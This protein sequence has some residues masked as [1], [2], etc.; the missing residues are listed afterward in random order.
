MSTRFKKVVL[1]T[2]KS[3]KEKKID[4]KLSINKSNNNVNAYIRPITKSTIDNENEISLLSK[5]REENSFAFPTQF[6]VTLEG[7]KNWTKQLIINPTRILFFIESDEKN[8]KIIGHLGFYS[9]DFNEDSCEIDNVIR[10]E[11]NYLKGAMTLAMKT[12][13]GWAIDKLHPKKIYLRVFSDNKKAIKFYKACGFKK[14]L[15]I[16]LEKEERQNYVSWNENKKLAKAEKY[17]LKM[18]YQNIK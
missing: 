13:I 12:M 15:L 7:T 3:I 9:F 10:G 2:F 14:C 5:W 16:P 18:V 1:T 8:P 17:F 6:K 11:K 4:I